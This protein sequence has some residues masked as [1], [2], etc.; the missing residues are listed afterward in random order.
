MI[1]KGKVI[2]T[3]PVF[4]KRFMGKHFTYMHLTIQGARWYKMRKET[5]T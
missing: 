2:W 3:P 4:R 1:Y 5:L